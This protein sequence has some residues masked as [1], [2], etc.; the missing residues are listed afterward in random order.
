M[1]LATV[2]AWGAWIIIIVAVDPTRAGSLGQFYFYASLAAALLG[3]LA[4]IGAML[5]LWMNHEELA[6]RQVSQA[7][8]QAIIFSFLIIGC[9]LMMAH[10]LMRWWSLFLLMATISCLELA[11]LLI[12]KNCQP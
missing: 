12:Q 9:L 6:V 3:S 1:A 10:D 4:V 8:R 5:R 11:G 7:L 2:A